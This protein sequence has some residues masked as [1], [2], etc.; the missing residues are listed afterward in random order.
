M[1]NVMHR[2]PVNSRLMLHMTLKTILITNFAFALGLWYSLYT[3]SDAVLFIVVSL[4]FTVVMAFLSSRYQNWRSERRHFVISDE[5]LEIPRLYRGRLSI[6]LREMKSLERYRNSQGE[7][8]LIQIGRRGKSSVLIESRLF[9]RQS[10]FVEF[11]ETLNKLTFEKSGETSNAIETPELGKEGHV[12]VTVVA[13]TIVACYLY[14][15]TPTFEQVDQE[16][17]MR[18]AL[19]KGKLDF[20]VISRFCSSFFLHFTPVHLLTN[21]LALTILGQK[22]VGALGWA[23][24]VLILLSSAIAGALLSLCF[25]PNDLVI[26]ASGGIFG[27]FGAYLI[28]CIRYGEN[29]PGSVCGSP[30]AVVLILIL[31]LILDFTQ[32]NVDVYS[33]LGGLSYG[34]LF[35]MATS[36]PTMQLRSPEWVSLDKALALSLSIAFVAAALYALN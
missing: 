22:I 13:I 10:D 8:F 12:A 11:L 34:A 21:V 7:V 5:S 30:R 1:S 20:D 3:V 16:I 24:F 36:R 15:A 4:S 33:H 14:F 6:K 26:G 35:V 25:S 17:L 31:Q 19:I 18:G 2:W 32:D 27:L 29:L 23:K 9:W 28:I